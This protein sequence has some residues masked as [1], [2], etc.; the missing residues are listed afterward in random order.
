M[1]RTNPFTGMMPPVKKV[2]Y[3]PTHDPAPPPPLPP[4]QRGASFTDGIQ[5]LATGTRTESVYTQLNVP[6]AIGGTHHVVDIHGTYSTSVQQS[7]KPSNKT[8]DASKPTKSWVQ[9]M[10]QPMGETSY[11]DKDKRSKAI[12]ATLSLERA[13]IEGNAMKY[14]AEDTY[15]PTRATARSS[16]ASQAKY[17]GGLTMGSFVEDITG[18]RG[19]GLGL[20]GSGM[21]ATT[22]AGKWHMQNVGAPSIANFGSDMLDA[23][24]Q[25]GNTKMSPKLGASVLRDKLDAGGAGAEAVR[26]KHL[27]M[28]GSIYQAH[29]RAL[30]EAGLRFDTKL[31]A[32]HDRTR[33]A[34]EQGGWWQGKGVALDPLGD[35]VHAQAR[36]Q[37]RDEYV[38]RKLERHAIAHYLAPPDMASAAFAGKLEQIR[39]SGATPQEAGK[40]WDARHTSGTDWSTVDKASDPLEH[41]QLKRAYVAAKLTKSGHAAELAEVQQKWASKDAFKAELDAIRGGTA[42]TT[43]FWTA[44]A[45]TDVTTLTHDETKALRAQYVAA[46]KP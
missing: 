24:P 16:E 37:L 44:R 21:R 4:Q 7:N 41:Q 17:F 30:R 19:L 42:S 22:M 40:W 27:G 15:V 10:L 13:T 35:P 29:A 20:V 8:Y 12:P 9:G 2:F 31:K 43:P 28:R 33:T 45:G 39:S 32:I 5:A 36:E 26:D 23:Y 14:L 11:F 1:K 3:E 46:H 18:A 34:V 25:L 6:Y 38:A